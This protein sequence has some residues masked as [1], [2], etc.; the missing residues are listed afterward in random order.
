MRIAALIFLF[1]SVVTGG[2]IHAQI[3]HGEVLD[4][5]TKKP[6]PG[7][8]IE[9]IYNNIKISTASDGGFVIAGSAG[10][11]LEFRVSGYKVTRVRIP[12]GYMPSW[13]KIIMEHPLKPPSE[14]HDYRYDS[15]KAREMYAG[16]LDF[17]RMSTIEQIKSPFSALS[18]YNRQVWAFQDVFLDAEK[19]KYVNHNFSPAIVSRITGLSNDS[20]ARFMVRFRPS[21]EQLKSMSEYTFYNY[22]KVSARR[23]RNIDRPVN[24]Q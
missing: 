22:V 8:Q 9:N 23:F 7:V 21:Y 20:L 19:E 3:I 24:S 6:I 10:E 1:L 18:K 4:M 12:H 16:V 11:L 15:I 2:S 13:F 17:P 5:D 14:E